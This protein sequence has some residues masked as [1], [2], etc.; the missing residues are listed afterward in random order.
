[1]ASSATSSPSASYQPAFGESCQV[2]RPMPQA[3]SRTPAAVSSTS[4]PPLMPSSASRRVR[5]EPQVETSPV[6]TMT[7]MSSRSVSTSPHSGAVG[8]VGVVAE[9]R[10]R[11]VTAGASCGSGAAWAARPAASSRRATRSTPSPSPPVRSAST[12]AWAARSRTAGVHRATS[13]LAISWVDQVRT[14]AASTASTS[15]SLPPMRPVP[16]TQPMRGCARVT[17]PDQEDSERQRLTTASR[18]DLTSP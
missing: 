18:A 8:C 1:M 14:P 6:E 5:P 17:R 9:G 2:S 7:T 13:S 12:G 11:M 10:A 4:S 16:R 15:G 3:S